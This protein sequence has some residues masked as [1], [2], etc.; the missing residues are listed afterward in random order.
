MV[1]FRGVAGHG[2]TQ[3]V[4]SPMRLRAD[5]NAGAGVSWQTYFTVPMNNAVEF[6]SALQQI[7]VQ[8]MRIIWPNENHWVLSPEDS[9]Q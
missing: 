8:S 7:K 9:R 6:W 1:S 3:R 4:Q 5:L 2:F